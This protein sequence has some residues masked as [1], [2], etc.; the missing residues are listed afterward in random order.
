[1][2]LG[3][4]L[5]VA[6]QDQVDALF[7]QAGQFAMRQ[8]DILD[9]A[10]GEVAL[11]NTPGIA[12]EDWEMPQHTASL[13]PERPRYALEPT[14][15]SE[16]L[17]RLDFKALGESVMHVVTYDFPEAP[18]GDIRLERHASS[19]PLHAS[20]LSMKDVVKLREK[21]KETLELER[22]LGLLD[23]GND[24]ANELLA[25]LERTNR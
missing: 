19:K 12:V 7:M 23:V 16:S 22:T 18:G 9:A 15:G 11:Y 2:S 21:L 6:T 1:M 8:R 5:P 4:E 20:K 24:E 3:P 13:L 14:K 17:V 10:G 25:F